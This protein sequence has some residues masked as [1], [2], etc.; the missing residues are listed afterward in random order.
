MWAAH[1]GFRCAQLVGKLGMAAETAWSLRA[2]RFFR[3]GLIDVGD[4]VLG[5]LNGV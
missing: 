4:Q 5:P 1:D 2:A 3:D